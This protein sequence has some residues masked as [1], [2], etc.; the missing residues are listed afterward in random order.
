M[1]QL[2]L[3]TGA[4]VDEGFDRYVRNVRARYDVSS[5]ASDTVIEFRKRADFSKRSLFF[6]RSRIRV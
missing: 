3:G 1:R 2:H 5:D 4:T 6:A